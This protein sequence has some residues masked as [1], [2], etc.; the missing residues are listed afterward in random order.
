MRPFLQIKRLIRRLLDLEVADGKNCVKGNS[1]FKL[2][3]WVVN[4]DLDRISRN[5][6]HV[7]LQPQ[8]MDL[9]VYLAAHHRE[10]IAGEELLSELWKNR[11]VTSSSV[12]SCLRQLREALGD[13]AQ[14]PKY[15]KTIP[16]RGYRLIA[17]PEFQDTK[18]PVLNNE[19]WRR[20]INSASDR[21]PGL[22]SF[23][24]GGSA[25][26]VL[27]FFIS[28]F[29]NYSQRSDSATLV[30]GKSIAVLPFADETPGRDDTWFAEGFSEEIMHMLTKLP[31]LKVTGRESSSIFNKAGFNPQSANKTLGVEHILQGSIR[32]DGN[33]IEVTAR[34]VRTTDGTFIW[35]NDY[36]REVV[37]TFDIQEHIF[38]EI[39]EELAISTKDIEALGAT[40]SS[41]IFPNFPAYELYLQSLSLIDLNTKLSLMSALTKLER[42]LGLDPGFARAHVGMARAYERLNNFTGYYQQDQHR[43]WKEMARPHLEKALALDPSIA[44]AYAIL[45]DI[46]ENVEE[47]R[48]LLQK[49]LSLNQNLY[50]VHIEFGIQIMDQLRSWNEIIPHLERALEIEPL[51]VEAAT[52]LVLFLQRVPHRWKDG[53][54]I[55]ANLTLQHPDSHD[56]KMARALWSMWVNGRPSEAVPLLEEVIVVDPDNA[57]ARAFLFQA[58]YILGETERAMESDFSSP[59]W[60]Y[61]LADDRNESLR[62]LNDA[63]EQHPEL[64]T[65]PPLIYAYT[66]VMLGDWQRAVDQLMPGAQD[67]ESYSQGFNVQNLALNDSPI[68]SLAVAYKKLGDH[69]NFV[70]FSAFERRAVNIR[71]ENGRLNNWDYS[72]AMSRLNALDGKHYQALLELERLVT[73]GN[74]DP[75]DLLHPAFDEMRTEPEFQRLVGLQHQ[76]I[77]SER[78]NLELEPLPNNNFFRVSAINDPATK[79]DK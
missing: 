74:L 21:F 46:S 2:G 79:S 71:T 16:K 15:I 35:A 72:R 3:H 43:G 22:L 59:H 77:N 14:N 57:F 41:S 62:Q 4:P 56:V 7:Y 9:L 55:L 75:R 29:P 33:R 63:F 45:G 6:E 27:A 10:V 1:I 42:A 19:F 31:G 13:D 44:E 65:Y 12:Y 30:S 58:W 25:L 47:A 61:V 32:Q 60:R 8:V 40:G 52:M 18:K 64:I 28:Q 69:A 36:H 53:E 78:K 73:M 70:K 24:L 39:V 51:S 11:V 34:L 37:D 17:Q 76:R 23:F 68:M 50:R 5:D 67:L 48:Q 54:A 38:N 20:K 49:A 66:Y 26:I